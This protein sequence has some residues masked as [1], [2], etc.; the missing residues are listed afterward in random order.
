MP[1]TYATADNSIVTDG[2]QFVPVGQ[3]TGLSVMVGQL[4][5]AQ[6]VLPFVAQVA[7]AA[8]P[9]YTLAALQAALI[10]AGTIP[11]PSAVPSQ[12]I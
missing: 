5:A 3:P 2:L 11:P 9:A 4:I 1:W 6:A 7:V 12:G 8:P 10:K